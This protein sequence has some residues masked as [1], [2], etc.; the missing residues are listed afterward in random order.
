M[1]NLQNLID[2]LK[3]DLR[4]ECTHL[5]FYLQSASLVQGLHS[6]E[7]KEHFLSESQ[8]EIKHVQQFA[9]LI[10]GL[11]GE[12][13]EFKPYYE[14]MPI[15]NSTIDILRQA[16]CLEEEVVSN[17]CERMHQAEELN[18]T[19]GDWVHIFLE[20]QIEDSRMDV[21]ELKQII[22]GYDSGL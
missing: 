10:I 4:N 5:M 21:D 8:K 1:S 22:R 12:G 20:K 17:Y 7:Y 2:L 3:S 16:L 14:K 13:L 6:K 9:D 11:N 19:D 15:T 18:S